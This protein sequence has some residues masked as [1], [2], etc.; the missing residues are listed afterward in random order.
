M[1]DIRFR[2]QMNGIFGAGRWRETG[3]YRSPAM[4]DQL[5]AE[6]AMTVPPGHLSRHSMGAPGA[7]GAYDVV[8]VGMSPFDAAAVLRRSGAPFA[9][10]LPET[11][12]GTQGAH[13]H[14]EPIS[15]S[16]IAT[17]DRI[18]N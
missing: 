16:R 14:I 1:S 4:E 11:T 13:L 10:L 3:G 8:V 18:R 6:G 9:K 7:P 5:R 12:H 15:T 17:I 2:A